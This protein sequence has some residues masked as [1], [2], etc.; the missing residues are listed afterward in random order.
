[1]KMHGSFK[2]DRLMEIKVKWFGFN[3]RQKKKRKNRREIVTRKDV[4]E[5]M[6]QLKRQN[7]TREKKVAEKKQRKAPVELLDTKT[8]SLNTVK[9]SIYIETQIM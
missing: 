7:D 9:M 6:K 4:A 5:A 8:V 2:G 3:C 1:M